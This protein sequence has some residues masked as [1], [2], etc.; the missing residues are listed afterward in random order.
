MRFLR[1]RV[2]A[3]ACFVALWGSPA[4]AQMLS[5]DSLTKMVDTY[6]QNEANSS[7][8]TKANSLKTPCRSAQQKRTFSLQTDT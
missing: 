3:A 6:R 1:T 2:F 4:F 5:G 8:T 7:A